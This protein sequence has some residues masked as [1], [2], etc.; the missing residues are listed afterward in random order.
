[1]KQYKIVGFIDAMS[2]LCFQIKHYTERLHQAR[3]KNESEHKIKE[4]A[5]LRSE[6]YRLKQ[7]WQAI[8]N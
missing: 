7:N 4:V 2:F 1:M 5:Y 8:N 3:T 6:L